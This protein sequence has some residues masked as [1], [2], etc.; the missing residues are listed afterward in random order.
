MTARRRPAFTLVE[1]IVSMAIVA[2][3]LGI[4]LP[5]VQQVRAASA[6][7][8]CQNHLHQ[9]AL[10]CHQYHGDRGVLPPGVQLS[11][12]PTPALFQSW[13]AKILP[14][15]E[16][17][18]LWQQAQAAYAADPNPFDNPPHTGLATVVP[19][20]TCPSDARVG[21]PQLAPK[22]GFRVAFTSY[23]GVSGRDANSLDGVL[24]RDSRVRFADVTDGASGTLLIGERPPSAD[25]Q[26]GWWYAGLGQ[27]TTGSAD[28]L[29]GVAEQNLLPIV[30]GS[31]C[32]PGSYPYRA[33]RFG[34]QCDMFHYWSPHPGGANF[35]FVDGSV[36]LVRYEANAILP[37]LASRAGGEADALAD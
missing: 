27:V 24:F 19:L 6:R 11:P 2:V 1:L 17:G 26:F 35:A 36:R 16:Q 10:A 3:L 14:Y 37:A 20:Y 33:G 29:L 25:F 15:V 9:I 13:L 12:Q 18:A 28:M 34:D 5:A 22:S 8:K 23:L 4:L 7:S 21:Q 30:A 31:P 32:G